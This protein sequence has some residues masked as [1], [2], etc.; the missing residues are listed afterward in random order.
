MLVD[1]NASR[2]FGQFI[3]DTFATPDLSKLPRPMCI[4]KISNGPKRVYLPVN[5]DKNFER[6]SNVVKTNMLLVTKYCLVSNT[7]AYPKVDHQ[8][9]VHVI[10]DFL[11]YQRSY[12]IQHMHWSF[13]HKYVC[14]CSIYLHSQ[15]V[16]TSFAKQLKFSFFV[17]VGRVRTKCS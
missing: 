7:F 16:I 14:M 3:P 15:G 4:K 1:W 5:L 10:L 11:L 17:G 2:C 8:N 9:W 13:P 12:L 6:I